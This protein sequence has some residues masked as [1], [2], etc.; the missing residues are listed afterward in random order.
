[1]QAW[2]GD[3]GDVVQA[4]A[5]LRTQNPRVPITRLLGT[6]LAVFV[7]RRHAQPISQPAFATIDKSLQNTM[8][9]MNRGVTSDHGL[10]SQCPKLD[11]YSSN[12]RPR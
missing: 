12:M 3:R 2:F 6:P 1:M 9:A 10:V 4:C 8:F 5:T 7:T 11:D